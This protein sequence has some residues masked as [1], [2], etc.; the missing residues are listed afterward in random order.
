MAAGWPGAVVEA[1]LIGVL[2]FLSYVKPIQRL[3][4]T[5]QRI[6]NIT[7][8]TDE[9]EKSLSPRRKTFVRIQK[10]TPL[11]LSL[12]VGGRMRTWAWEDVVV[13]SYDTSPDI[14][15]F[16]AHSEWGDTYKISYYEV[17]P[18]AVYLRPLEELPEEGWCK[19]KTHDIPD[20][21]T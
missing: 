17:N 9:I 16:R 19:V 20:S 5:Y 21:Q 8:S 14:A 11:D 18:D 2:L 15:I 3:S 10:F 13:E 7:E 1:L 12:K 6:E 4:Q